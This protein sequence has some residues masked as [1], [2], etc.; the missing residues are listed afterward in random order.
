MYNSLSMNLLYFFSSSFSLQFYITSLSQCAFFIYIPFI[1]AKI[2]HL[3]K[4]RYT[5][6]AFSNA[7][8]IHPFSHPVIQSFCFIFFLHAKL[9]QNALYSFTTSPT[10]DFISS[11]SRE[12]IWFRDEYSAWGTKK[13]NF[14][15]FFFFALS[16]FQFILFFFV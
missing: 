12:Q 8:L 15:W 13:K 1:S 14:W 9:H 10:I 3:L 7:L 11:I 6:F 16:F 5:I 4:R 2:S